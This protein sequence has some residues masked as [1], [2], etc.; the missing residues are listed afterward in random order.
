MTESLPTDIDTIIRIAARGD[1][2]TADGRHAPMSAPGDLLRADG[3]V[4]PGPHR[5]EPV[6][7]HYPACGGCQ[8]QHLDEESFATFVRDRVAG[9]L[10]GRVRNTATSLVII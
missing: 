3:T 7:R 2:V 5:A 4:E 10:A 6:C 1:G 9:G 8:L